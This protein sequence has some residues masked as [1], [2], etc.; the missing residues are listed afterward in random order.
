MVGP[1]GGAPLPWAAQGGGAK[2]LPPYPV[3][4]SEKHPLRIKVNMVAV[5]KLVRGSDTVFLRGRMWF[6]LEVRI[7]VNSTRIR[8]PALE[9]EEWQLY[10]L[11]K[12]ARSVR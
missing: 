4:A 5:L 7:R 9:Y 10:A 6:F 1:G 12:I 11:S 2:G 8:K 3:S